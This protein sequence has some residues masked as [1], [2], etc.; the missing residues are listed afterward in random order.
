MRR[1]RGCF[2]LAG[3]LLAATSSEAAFHLW[4]VTEIY[5]N[6]DGS[7][8]FVE[9]FATNNSQDELFDHDVTSTATTYTIPHDLGTAD[10]IGNPNGGGNNATASRSFLIATPGFAALP[11]APT[12]DYVFDATNFF[13]T[14]ADTVTLVGADGLSFT[15]GE[16]PTDGVD[17]LNEDFGGSNRNVAVNSPTNFA[18]ETGSVDL[19]DAPPPA[20]AMNAVGVVSALALL[21]VAAIAVLAT[22]KRRPQT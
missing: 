7:V 18:G 13:D 19:S 8:Q 10:P 5:S 21:V 11:G 17:S 2:V 12:P 1:L 9:F 16:L 3:A 14:V 6:A 15:S 22:R 20:P 4:D